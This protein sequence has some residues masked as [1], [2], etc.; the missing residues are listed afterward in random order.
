MSDHFG[1]SETFKEI[2]HSADIC[3]YFQRGMRLL[4]V[5]KAG[6]FQRKIEKTDKALSI[7]KYYVLMYQNG[8]M[9]AVKTIPR[10]G[11]Q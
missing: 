10:M 7:W 6:R 8:K 5:L 2:Y 9:R 11:G 4:T 3:L 1:F